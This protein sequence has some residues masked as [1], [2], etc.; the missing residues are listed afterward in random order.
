MQSVEIDG[1]PGQPGLVADLNGDDRL[2]LVVTGS[3]RTHS[4]RSGMRVMLNTGS[5]SPLGTPVY[6]PSPDFPMGDLDAADVDLD[7]DI[8][9]VGSTIDA[10]M[11]A[12]NT[13]SGTLTGPAEFIIPYPSGDRAVADFTGDGKPD[14]WNANATDRSLYSVY[15]NVTRGS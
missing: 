15:K 14:V 10:L 13:G 2:D 7:G 12:V 4:G 8:D 9:I 3:R 1:G 5:T 11:V 6:Y